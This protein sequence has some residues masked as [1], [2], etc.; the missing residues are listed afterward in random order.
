MD[1]QSPSSRAVPRR[2]VILDAALI[3]LLALMAE[4]GHF[5]VR[6]GRA[7]T[8][9]DSMQYLDNALAILDPLVHA[10]FS[11]RKPGYS[12]LMALCLAISGGAGWAAVA[13]NHV[14]AAALAPLAYAFGLRLSGMRG[15]G[16]LAAVLTI[17]RLQTF[18]WSDRIL[19]EPLFAFLITAAL[20]ATACAAGSSKSWRWVL[21]GGVGLAAAWLVRASAT[22]VI[23]AM[24]VWLAWRFRGSG[25]RRL[26]AVCGCLL[27]PVMCAWLVE[28]T[29]NLGGTGVFRPCTGT[30]GPMLVMRGCS[31]QGAPLSAGA[32][33]Q[34]CLA[35][36]PERSADEAYR[37]N[38]LDAWVARARAV[39]DRGLNE[40]ETDALMRR[41]GWDTL[42]DHA[43]AYARTTAELT[44]LQLWRGGDRWLSNAFIRE[45][46]LPVITTLTSAPLC[47]EPPAWFVGCA[48]PHRSD[49][50]AAQVA[51][52]LR[53]FEITKA[54]FAVAEPWNTLR[55]AVMHPVAKACASAV[56]ALG[57]IPP[58]LS[59]LLCLW[60]CRDRGL[61]AILALVYVADALLAAATLTSLDV[62]PRM[63]DVWLGT[64]SALAATALGLASVRLARWRTAQTAQS[65][66]DELSVRYPEQTIPASGATA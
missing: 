27:V 14:L 32:S 42:M 57:G 49:E 61:C 4:A 33:Q 63:Q 55:Y 1:T 37:V 3:T 41:A 8:C 58:L 45:D 30:L 6:H 7:V 18:L 15:I 12:L 60:L 65:H 46:A 62:V 28:C 40:W 13:V 20:L 26:A 39:R 35:L 17:A 16:W 11:F 36:L 2:G 54:A 29:L 43:P 34:E 56:A 23:L 5:A 9:A 47:V 38:K 10:D 52:M 22:A 25:V 51:R 64:D 59:L 44:A 21:I 24:L 50:R 48:L 31:L 19:A 53:N 66:A